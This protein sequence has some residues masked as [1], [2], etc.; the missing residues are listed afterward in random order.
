MTLR[1]RR[2][3]LVTRLDERTIPGSMATWLEDGRLGCAACAH[4]CALRDGDRGICGVRW[5]DGDVLRVPFGYVARRYVRPIEANTIFHVLPGSRALTFGM[6]GCDLACGY[7]QNAYISQALRDGRDDQAPV[8]VSAEAL[9][10]EAVA[11]GCAAICAAFNE[12]MITLEWASAVFTEAK[13]RGLVTALITDGHTTSEA[14][15]HMRPVT[16]VFRVDIK[17]ADAEA[18]RSLGGDHAAVWAAIHRA[19]ELGYW[20]ELVTLIVPGLNDDPTSLQAM[21]KS[22]AAL[23]EDTVWHTNG[24]LP[25]HRMRD[26]P[27]TPPAALFFAASCGYGRGLR[28]VYASNVPGMPALNQTRCP[29][30]GA[31]VVERA[32]Y[33][34]VSSSL[35]GGSCGGCGHDIPGVWRTA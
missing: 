20:I 7:C 25:R 30:C 9:C 18:Y 35:V 13:K 10:D 24:F 27:P 22:V 14:L 32:D 15:E 11:A 34:T 29:G 6:F 33:Q 5:R 28:Y 8:D 2:L 4:R 1:G 12:P 17:A 26:R 16:D 3:S 19:R 31:A 21:A 23:G